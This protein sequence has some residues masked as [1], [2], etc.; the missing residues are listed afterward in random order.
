MIYPVVY[1]L[2][3]DGVSVAVT[4]R[5]LNL[6]S[7]GY[8][9]W[10][11]RPASDWAGELAHLMESI[12]QGRRVVQ[13]RRQRVG[14]HAASTAPTATAGCTPSSCWATACRLAMGAW[15]G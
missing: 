7:S 10:R 12:R 3:A 8:Y 11:R 4:C 15:S 1:E 2:A 5:V 14:V 13:D 9:E 6:S